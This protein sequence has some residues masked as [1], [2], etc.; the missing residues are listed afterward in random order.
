M[1]LFLLNFKHF[2][3]ARLSQEKALSISQNFADDCCYWEGNQVKGIE[4]EV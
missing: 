1:L 3:H 2:Y 4:E